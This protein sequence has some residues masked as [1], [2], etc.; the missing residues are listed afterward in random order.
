MSCALCATTAYTLG[1]VD[2]A[3][4]HP[5]VCV[6]PGWSPTYQG[7]CR[8]ANKRCASSLPGFVRRVE[9]GNSTR[10][11]RP[12]TVSCSCC[13]APSEGHPGSEGRRREVPELAT[14]LPGM[15]DKSAEE[16]SSLSESRLFTGVPISKKDQP[17]RSATWHFDQR[18]RCGAPVP[19][20]SMVRRKSPS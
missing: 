4:T 20:A 3:P 18:V 19:P 11:S 5:N 13:H 6:R 1:W 17:S 2:Q 12:W 14:R 7:F 15:N 16:A 10:I 9:I 8:F